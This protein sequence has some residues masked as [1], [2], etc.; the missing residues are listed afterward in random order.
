MFALT[1]S[2]ALL[3]TTSSLAAP[4]VVPGEVLLREGDTPP[5]LS[6]GALTTFS[7]VTLNAQGQAGILGSNDIGTHSVWIDGAIVWVSWDETTHNLVLGTNGGQRLGIGDGGE[8]ESDG[9]TDADGE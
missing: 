8:A 5:E 9:T 2:I 6:G 4:I 3:L 7:H 1:T